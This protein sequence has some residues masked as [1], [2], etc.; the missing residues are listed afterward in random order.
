ME[1]KNELGLIVVF[2]QQAKEAGFE[3][4]DVGGSYPDAVIRKNGIEYRTEF[5]FRARNFLEHKHDP[6]QCDLIICWENDFT[7]SALPVLALSEEG[8]WRKEIILASQEQKEISYWKYRALLAESRLKSA[9]RVSPNIEQDKQ[10]EDSYRQAVYAVL[11]TGQQLGPRP[12]AAAVGCS[13]ATAKKWIDSFQAEQVSMIT[14]P[15][16][17]PFEAGHRNGHRKG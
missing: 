15:A 3:I 5:E 6:R 2:A 17:I 13:P 12:M 10:D 4:V 7:E 16:D 8:W 11:R 14:D 9:T 1:I